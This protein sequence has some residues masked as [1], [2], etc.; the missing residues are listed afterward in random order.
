MTVHA[1][2]TP[3]DRLVRDLSPLEASVIPGPGGK[4]L[5]NKGFDEG[6]HVGDLWTVFGKGERVV[7]PSTGRHLGDMPVPVGRARVT[8]PER[9]FSEAVFTCIRPPCTIKPGMTVRRFDGIPAAFYDVDG[10]GRPLYE[11]CRGALS[12]LAWEEYQRIT[13]PS[14]ITP[15]GDAVIFV[16]KGGDLTVW[17]GGEI[18]GMYEAVYGTSKTS[19]LARSDAFVTPSALPAGLAGAR[20]SSQPIFPGLA[21]VGGIAARIDVRSYRAVGSLDTL[22]HSLEIDSLDSSGKPSFI[23]LSGRSVFVQPIGERE[24][25]Q[26]TYEGFGEVLSLSVGE[27]GLLALNIYIKGEGARS[28]ILKYADHGIHVVAKDLSYYLT[29]FDL[30]GDGTRESLIGENYDSDSFFGPGIYRLEVRN[31]SV[32]RVGDFSAPTGFILNGALVADLDGD[33]TLEMGYYNVG[34]KFVLTSRGR[35]VWTSPE[36]L[37]GSIKSFHIPSN[38]PQ[39]PTPKNII[40]WSQPAIVSFGERKVAVIPSNE[41]SLWNVVGGAPKK[42]GVGILYAS[43]GGYRFSELATEFAGPVQDVFVY[44]DELYIVVVEGNF[45]TGNGR[46]HVLALPLKEL[47]ASL[48]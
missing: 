9:L 43:G 33:G 12:H 44:K 15:K 31:G 38:E 21:G 36:A 2:E 8:R 45:F 4:N 29:F 23:Y 41:S 28:R 26:Y 46:T 24:R 16:A 22:V 11:W 7:D 13:D 5:I 20:T 3:K 42:G 1:A 37:G 10:V 40:L 27:D 18:R 14:G 35:E 32:K 19:P 48:R 47:A 17:S 30:D 39:T 6:V 34:K 25:Y